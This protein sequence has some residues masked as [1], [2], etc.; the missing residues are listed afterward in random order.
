M[1][2]IVAALAVSTIAAAQSPKDKART[3]LRDGLEAYSLRDFERA[4]AK[5]QEAHRAFPSPKLLVNIGAAYRELGKPVDALEHYERFFREAGPDVDAAFR[6]EAERDAEALR[7][8]VGTI[9]VRAPP[10][11][12]VTLD[13]V[14]VATRTLRV[15]PGDHRVTIGAHDEVVRVIG[16]ERVVVVP[17]REAPPAAP[18]MTPAPA[19]V[20]TAT[21]RPEPARPTRWKRPVGWVA[22]GL[23]AVAIGVGAVLAVKASRQADDYDALYDQSC[24]QMGCAS[25]ALAD[26]DEAYD[27]G[28]SLDRGAW[29]ALAAGG[30]LATGGA[31][32]LMWR[33]GD[34]R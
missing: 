17:P 29:I 33:Q 19:P 2:R 7:D 10:D 14:L 27:H 20:A 25:E 6:A 18:A 21:A 9:E 1:M 15:P 11:E 26:L 34:T 32:L 5:F 24:G 30:A 22:V 3:L 16:R 23:G 4:L 13:G 31:A 12:R 8:R 28:R